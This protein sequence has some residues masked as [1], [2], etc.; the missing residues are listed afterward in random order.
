VQIELK[1]SEEDRGRL[2][3][4]VN[5]LRRTAAEDSDR[6]TKAAA[7][8]AAAGSA[9]M[10]AAPLKVLLAAGESAAT[11]KELRLEVQGTR[12][13]RNKLFIVEN[14][15]EECRRRLHVDARE[16]VEREQHKV[17]VLQHEL[18]ERQ[19]TIERL[20]YDL[21]RSRAV[22]GSEDAVEEYVS[23]LN[24]QVRSMEEE[25]GNR[26]R[27]ETELG[28]KLLEQEHH[29][30]ELRFEREQARS[31]ISRLE[32]RLLELELVQTSGDASVPGAPDPRPTP[33]SRQVRSLEQVIEGLERVITQQK[34]ELKRA[35]DEITGRKDDRRHKAEVARL[36]KKI[37]SLED[38]LGAQDRNRGRTSGQQRQIAQDLAR[39]REAQ[40]VAHGE[41]EQKET[42]IVVLE[43]ELAAARASAISQAPGSAGA[44]GGDG[45][46]VEC[47]TMQLRELQF[48]RAADAKALDEAQTA[49]HEA[50]L[51]EKRYMEVANENKKLKADLS[52]L[53]DDGFWQEIEAIHARSDEATALLRDSREV[54]C[55]LLAACPSVQPPAHLLS[56]IENHIAAAAAAA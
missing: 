50:E 9:I 37:E 40:T 1:K 8:K 36:R 30:M 38:E 35:K 13:L 11:V 51:T 10:Q 56:R 12:E 4:E 16:D 3:R 7:A 26:R 46:E 34:A 42:Q 32:N 18:D 6:A 43:R 55:S 48:S 17:A 28:E 23:T 24:V 47:L 52:A 44:G 41:L 14:E 29:T 54:L 39:A 25:L 33:S 31:R 2:Q 15:L 27:A 5:E 19:R 49:L 53:H 45:A 22:A 20:S 21:R